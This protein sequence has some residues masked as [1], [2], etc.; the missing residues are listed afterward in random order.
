[1]S[2]IIS[3]DQGTTGTTIALID[4]INFELIDKVNNEFEQIYPVPGQVEHNLNDI[5]ATV[6]KGIKKLEE[7]Y[8]LNN[9]TIKTI[10]ITNQRETTCAFKKD[11]TP[12]YNAIVWQDRRTTA[13]CESIKS[14]DLEAE[15]KTKTGL[16]M[17]PYFSASKMNW[18]LNNSIKVQE[19]N[20]SSN[21]N[22][23]TIDTFLLY[24][25]TDGESF[26]TDTTNASRT[27]LMNLETCEWDNSLCE[28]FQINKETLPEIKDSI[29]EFGRTKGLDFLPD[30]IPVTGIL[31]DQQA[32]LFGQ[33]GISEGDI[34]CTYGTG[35]FAL[36]NTGEKIKR[37]EQGLL[38]TIAYSYKG[39]NFYALEGSSYIAG[40]AVQWLRDNLNFFETASEIENLAKK[41][42]NLSEIN[43]VCFFPYFSGI[44]T[45]YWKP[46]AKAAITGLT[47]DTNKSHISFACLEGVALTINDL[48]TS[49]QMDS[50]LEVEELKVDGGAVANNLLCNIQANISQTTIVRP[51]V[52]ETTAYGA[53]LAAAIGSGI[54]DI[55]QIADKWK[56]D[57][58]FKK[59]NNDYYQNKLNKWKAFQ[60]LLFLN[61]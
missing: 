37:S 52:I 24:K 15:I 8:S 16:I 10:G 29:G 20:E 53:A 36:I 12:L 48:M 33:A 57:K 13:Y 28:L 56:E 23:G 45:P 41:V 40:A 30:G 55:S 46:E 11:G 17:D 34:K 4:A 25:L 39:K 42:T 2:Y 51:K 32:A 18:L 27:L 59:D 9:E 43:D 35:A 7:K 6:S 50:Q 22:F 61:N 21:L 3:I 5:W 31:G 26:Y 54:F 14:R 1:M 49:I 60:S 47:R 58:K 38:S 19:A 44:G